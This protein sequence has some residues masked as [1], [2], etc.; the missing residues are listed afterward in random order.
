MQSTDQRIEQLEA[1]NR[2]LKARLANAQQNEQVLSAEETL[3]QTLGDHLPNGALFRFRMKASVL[4]LPDAP[5]IW[6]KQI[7]LVYASSTWEKISNVPLADAM[8]NAILPFKKIYPDDLSRIKP[9]IYEAICS[10]STFN[11]EIRY[12]YSDDVIQ[13]L[14]MSANIHIEGEW[15]MIDGFILDITNRKHI[16]NELSLHRE[17]LE[18]LVKERT[19]NLETTNLE[20][21]TTNLELAVTNNE[22]NLYRTQLEM[23]VELK[24]NQQGILIKVLKILQLFGS[25]P[26]ALNIVLA[27][28]GKFTGVSRVYIFEKNTVNHSLSNTHEWCNEGVVS[29]MDFSQQIYP[30]EWHNDLEQGKYVLLSNAAA[31]NTI[32]TEAL[33]LRGSL[34]VLAIPLATD[35]YYGFLGFDECSYDREW[36]KNEIDLL[37]SLSQI[38][39]N[40]MRRYRAETVMRLSQQAMRTV[41]DNID[42]NVFVSD[43]ETY[44]ILFANRKIKEEVGDVEG[45]PCWQVMHKDM[46]GPCKFCPKPRLRDSN[47]QP[48]GLYQWECRNTRNHNWFSCSN[49]AIEWVD[50]RLVHLEYATNITQR[51]NTEIELI[52]AKE[53]AEESDKLKSAF[54][55]NMSHEIRTPL[56]AMTGFLNFMGDDR[57]TPARRNEYS[58]IVNNSADQLSRLIDDIVDVAI[59]EAGQMTL[60]PV[61]FRLN[62]FME[63]MYTFFDTKL[64][65][66]GRSHAAMAL[67]RSG[68][69]ENCVCYIDSIRLRQI[70]VN[71]MDNA[72]KFLDKGYICFGYR[73]TEPGMIEFIVEDTGVGIPESQQNIIFDRFRKADKHIDRR[74]RGTGLGL[75]ISR[76]L[77]QMMGGDIRVESTEGFGSTFHFTVAYLP[78]ASADLHIFDLL[79]ENQKAPHSPFDGK[80]ILVTEPIDMK[81]IYYS[82]MLSS[83]GF[84]VVRA[85]SQRWFD[86]DAMNEK[87]DVAL[88]SFSVAGNVAPCT[89]NHLFTPIIYI[90][91]GKPDEYKHLVSHNPYSMALAEPLDYMTLTDALLR[92]KV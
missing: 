67:D 26:D 58:N 19:E 42:A 85:E 70:F 41:L 21:E 74:Y 8:Q 27:E 62:E 11:V 56:N 92:F 39:T 66:T 48:T 87:M 68:F 2:G 33:K 72:F 12:L 34:S 73:Q 54:L 36:K 77:V 20:L 51:K 81:F 69:V 49:S 82:K 10:I 64:Y 46:T 40:T 60:F 15:I 45:K 44:E 31:K 13:W 24:T 3:L 88:I 79:T 1:E 35:E 59:I 29:M 75:T 28:I 89:I 53:K 91:P 57:L 90:V 63:D 16:E 52:Q 43:F 47:N 9:L 78:V 14:Q 25:T 50:G 7:Q 32:E 71:L 18:R 22:L 5:D 55:A 61:V 84:K 6:T 30:G 86:F 4:S 37:I 83:I 76:S 80:T 65:A 38:L 23:M 17:E